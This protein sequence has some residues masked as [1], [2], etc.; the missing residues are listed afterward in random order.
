MVHTFRL[1][2]WVRNPRFKQSYLPY[3][4]F[5]HLS[6]CEKAF[7]FFYGIAFQFFAVFSIGSL[8]SEGHQDYS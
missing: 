5:A 4:S 6:H 2:S 1:F 7:F 8:S 3:E